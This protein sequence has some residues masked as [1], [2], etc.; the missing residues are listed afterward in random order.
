SYAIHVVMP[1]VKAVP[2]PAGVAPATVAALLLQGLTAHYL[3][4]STFPLRAGHTAVIHAAEGGVGQLLLQLAKRAGARVLA[5]SSS[6]EKH[7]LIRALGADAVATYDDFVAEAKRLTNGRGVD[8]VYDSVGA[9]TVPGSLDSLAPRGLLALFG[10]S[11]GPVPPL[12]PQVLSAKGSLFLTRPKLQDY[13]LTREELLGRCTDLFARINAGELTV[14]IDRTVPLAQAADAH[15]ALE[16]RA[17]SGKIIL[18]P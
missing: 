13:T 11:S 8:V 6:P 7:A 9:T 12:D 10:Q 3:A 17:T 1:A 2:V 16:G 4:T 5:T 15:R 18:T 14:R